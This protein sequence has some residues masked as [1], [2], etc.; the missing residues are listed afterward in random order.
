MPTTR[1]RIAALLAT[2]PQP[3][4][5]AIAE[6]VGVSRQR[7]QQIALALGLAQAVPRRRRRRLVA[8]DMPEKRPQFSTTQGRVTELQVAADLIARGWKVYWPLSGG[9][10]DLLV[11]E[12]PDRVRRVEVRPGKRLPNGAI[13]WNCP[14]AVAELYAIVISPSEIE[15]RKTREGEAVSDP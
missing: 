2:S 6:F 3:T 1:E 9:G 11:F 15:Y 10:P 5:A 14:D 13:R 4:Y 12:R 7:V 8:G